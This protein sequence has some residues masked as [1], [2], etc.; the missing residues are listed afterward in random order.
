MLECWKN[1][2]L[3]ET[4]VS[5]FHLSKIPFSQSHMKTSLNILI[6]F[7]VL[8]A[9]SSAEDAAPNAQDI[10]SRLNT[11]LLDGSSSA[12]VKMEIKPS[13]EGPKT[14]L[15]LQIKTRRTSTATDI[16]YQV[17]WPKER[18]GESI[19]LHKTPNQAATGTVFVPPDSMKTLTAAQMKDGVFGSDLCYE[20]LVGNFFAWDNQA[21]VGTETVDRI[22][23][24]ILES[25][26]GK[27]DHTAFARVRSW[28]DVK[29]LVP[30][31]I[32]KYSAS[33][34]MESR[35]TTTRV[36]K[37]DADR[38]VPATLLVQRAGSTSVTELEGS[39]SRYD[40]TYKDADFTPDALRA[41]S[42]PGAQN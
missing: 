12:R 18:K 39:K 19:L 36:A 23:C 24:Q 17:L 35:I 14:V 5:P 41:L 4:S 30:M 29:K 32:E 9:H 22:P 28:I 20:D 6:A 3:N 11:A 1:E 16:I 31:R 42:A 13:A 25:K 10:A 38:P 7:T 34:N 8:V 33:G 40:V 21:L 26:S 37:N 2:I 27:N 15:Q